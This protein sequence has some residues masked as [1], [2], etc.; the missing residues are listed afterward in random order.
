MAQVSLLGQENNKDSRT[1]PEGE[2][3][4]SRNTHRITDQPFLPRGGG[5]HLKG[6]QLKASIIIQTTVK[7]LKWGERIGLREEGEARGKDAQALPR[8]R[9]KT[10]FIEGVH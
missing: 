5:G 9:V 3:W 10:R 2:R 6:R 7:P 1:R 8:V 4:L